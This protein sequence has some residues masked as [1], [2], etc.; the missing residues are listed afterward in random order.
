M[1]KK[2]IVTLCNGGFLAATGHSLPV[3]HFYKFHKFKRDVAKANRAIGEA[4]TDLMRDCGIDPAKFGEASS[5]ALERFNAANNA[6]IQEDAGV[7][8]KARIPMEC[9]KEFYDENRTQRGDIFASFPVE[10]LVLDNLFTEPNEDTGEGDD[11]E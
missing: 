10:D 2:D 3:E 11:D 5:E 9:Y 4:Q 1:K 8:V 6:M 7:E